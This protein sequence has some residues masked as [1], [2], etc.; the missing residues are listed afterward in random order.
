M[1]FVRVSRAALRDEFT[2]RAMRDDDRAH[3]RREK[4]FRDRAHF[5]RNER[6]ECGARGWLELDHLSARSASSRDEA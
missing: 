4:N 5:F 2:T 3:A 6:V 1:F